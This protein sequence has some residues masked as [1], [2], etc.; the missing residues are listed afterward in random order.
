MINETL[1][2]DFYDSIIN[3]FKSVKYNMKELPN[4]KKR[5]F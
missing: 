4:E 5:P 1:K 2:K 3:E